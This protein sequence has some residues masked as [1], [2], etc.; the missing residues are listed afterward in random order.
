MSYRI[1]LNVRIL[2][3]GKL[4]GCLVR[5]SLTATH[6]GSLSW[7][8]DRQTFDQYTIDSECWQRANLGGKAIG[9]SYLYEILAGS[10]EDW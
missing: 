6:L 5:T 8:K 1:G 2:G 7:K 10:Q 9:L 3:I 4:G